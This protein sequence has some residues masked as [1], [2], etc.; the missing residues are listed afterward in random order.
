MATRRTSSDPV[1]VAVFA[2]APQPGAAKTR[3]IPALGAAGAAR[4]QRR[5]I[6]NALNVAAGFAADDVTLWCA[7]DTSHRFFRA[8]QTC[9]GLRVCSQVGSD[10]GKRMANTFSPPGPTLLIGTDCPAITAGHLARAAKLLHTGHDAVFIPAEDGGY[11]LVGLRRA[12]P[13]LFEDIEWGSERVMAQT[14]QRLTELGLHWAEPATLWDLDRP[15]DLARLA[16][17]DG[18]AQWPRGK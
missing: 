4:L 13:R 2:R 12:Q 7:P 17:V 11:V 16:G 5:L 10:L 3:L 1:H 9:R 18:F 15:A 6:L 8:L 14:R